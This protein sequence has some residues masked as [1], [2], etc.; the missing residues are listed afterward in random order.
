V[1]IGLLALAGCSTTH[2]T[3]N[4][5]AEQVRPDAGYR[6]QR[7]FAGDPGDRMYMQVSVSGGGARL[8]RAR[9]DA[10]HAHCL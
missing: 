8:R 5:R 10:R 6:M 7:V 3:V 4:E 9:G 2:Y 1:L